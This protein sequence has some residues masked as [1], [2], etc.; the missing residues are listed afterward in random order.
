LYL[1]DTDSMR[2]RE[3]NMTPKLR[4]AFPPKVRSY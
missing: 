3:V 2:R 4:E 1:P